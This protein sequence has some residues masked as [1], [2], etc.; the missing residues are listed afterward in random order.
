VD[1]NSDIEMIDG[2]AAKSLATRPRDIID[3]DSESDHDRP[4]VR[5]Q[6]SCV[7]IL[8]SMSICSQNG[9]GKNL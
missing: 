5:S 8:G 6:T 7:C 1:D 9:P 2:P 4:P 3:V